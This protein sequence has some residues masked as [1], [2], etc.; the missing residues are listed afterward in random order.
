MK[1]KIFVVL[2][3]L[4]SFMIISSTPY[5][6]GGIPDIGPLKGRETF[7]GTDAEGN[8]I[9]GVT[10]NADYD[11]SI[12]KHGQLQ[13]RIDVTKF[14]SGGSK[15]EIRV[16]F[17]FEKPLDDFEGEINVLYTAASDGKTVIQNYKGYVRNDKEYLYNSMFNLNN[18]DKNSK[19][20]IE[21]L[22][23]NGKKLSV[24]LKK[25]VSSD[26]IFISQRFPEINE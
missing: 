21:F 8:Y 22:L 9:D 6:P 24:N 11:I 7:W 25:S 18:A 10:Y 26:W 16:L 17:V 20:T 5:F 4:F 12:P 14:Y 2:L 15:S 3:F 1:N 19:V 23:N 13:A